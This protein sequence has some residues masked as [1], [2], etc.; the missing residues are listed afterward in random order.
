MAEVVWRSIG[1]SSLSA[2]LFGLVVC[3]K[4]P[5]INSAQSSHWAGPN[6][7]LIVADDLGYSDIGSFGSEIKTPNLDALAKHGIKLT[8]FYAAPTC[9]PS[10][11]MMLTGVDSHLAGL[12]TMAERMTFIYEGVPGYEGYLNRDVVTVS[13]VLKQGGYRTYMT[14]KWHFGH[15]RDTSPAA[16]GFDR[17]FALM[18]GGGS[19]LN[20]RPQADPARTG[21]HAPH[22]M[23]DGRDVKLPKDFYSSRF[24][25][26]KMIEYFKADRHSKQPFFAYLSFTAPHFPLQA[27]ESSR[28]KYRGAYVQGYDEIYAQRLAKMRALGIIADHAGEFVRTGNQVAWEDLS[29]EQQAYE[30]RR[31]ELHAAMVDDMDVYIGEVLNYLKQIG[32]YDNTFIIF[33]SDNGIEWREVDQAIRAI[34]DWPHRCCDNSLENMGAANSYIWLGPNWGRV[35]SGPYRMGKG[36]TA[37][38]GIRVPAIIHYPPLQTKKRVVSS[39]ASILDLT[40]TFLELA[41]LSHPAPQFQGSKVHEL[42]GA[43]MLSY[44][45]GESESF[46]DPDYVMGWELT[47]RRAVKQGDWKLLWDKDPFGEERWTLY[48][49]VEDPNE[50]HDLSTQESGRLAKMIKYW[51]QYQQRNNVVLPN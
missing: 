28:A 1:F 5:T 49:L 21:K 36:S 24:Y 48:N 22:Y 18:D 25:A 34:G 32:E 4:D 46:H 12:G 29:D 9:S 13:E 41:G 39:F 44:L 20:N 23:E 42:Q 40:P 3:A 8:N 7:L 26:E 6:F 14:G 30:A 19:H 15:D 27:P 37:D 38:G 45:R 33:M 50:L 17:S 2:I 35:A 11:A 51:E 47:N 43:S 16:R 31:M 10:R